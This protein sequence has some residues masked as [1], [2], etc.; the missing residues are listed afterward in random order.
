MWPD[1]GRAVV[2][3]PRP[4]KEREATYIYM[5]HTGIYIYIHVSGEQRMDHRCADFGVE[6]RGVQNSRYWIACAS[7]GPHHLDNRIGLVDGQWE[8]V[9]YP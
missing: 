3:R 5:Y 8:K 4:I 1:R 2:S 9:S 6:L 7:R